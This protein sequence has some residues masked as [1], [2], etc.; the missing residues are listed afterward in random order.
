MSSAVLAGAI[1]I[2]SAAAQDSDPP[3]RAKP[4]AAD[5]LGKA[6]VDVRSVFK[7][8]YANKT[9]AGRKALTKK[10]LEDAQTLANDP[11]S[12]Y[13][14]LLEARD[15]SIEAGDVETAVMAIAAIEE[16]Y[17]ADPLA[18]R[19]ELVDGLSKLIGVLT[20]DSAAAMVEVAAGLVDDALLK[21]DLALA[22]KL[23]GHAEN[24]LRRVG[25]PARSGMLRGQIGEQK[26]I[27][28]LFKKA[29]VMQTKL[30]EDPASQEALAFVGRYH[31][32]IKKSFDKGLPLLAKSSDA[33]TRSAAEIE[34]KQNRQPADWAAAGDAW[35]ASAKAEKALVFRH[36]MARRAI[37][38][39][40]QAAQELTGLRKTAAQQATLE[41]YK[42]AGL[43]AG[44][45]KLTEQ[46]RER[47]VRYGDKW[48]LIVEKNVDWPEAAKWCEDRN[49]TLVSI[50][51]AAEN[52]FIWKMA[53]Q[54]Y[55]K[56]EGI[57]LWLGGSDKDKE[58]NWRWQDGT[59]VRYK[60]WLKGQPDNG[61][62]QEHYM[63]MWGYQR[64]GTWNDSPPNESFFFVAQ[65]KMK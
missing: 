2:T 24:A 45:A 18:L 17:E 56:T 10:L 16:H 47:L 57:R 50:D 65:W 25:D 22:T 13:A 4:P 43:P 19:L 12:R 1:F 42:T 59:A 38:W 54:R 23:V 6:I 64:G 41:A 27:I 28:A 5:A 44:Y 46:E 14:M 48:L 63:V 53:R 61:G 15:V 35:L 7:S 49:G 3:A 58:S 30:L 34:L 31:C 9:L 52:E 40:D 21:E 26:E 33:S 37:F 32:F 60:N 29:D 11:V 8:L 20:P 55:P 62:G 36:G 39:Y 51:S